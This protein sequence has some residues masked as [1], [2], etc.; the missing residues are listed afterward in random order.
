[1]PQPTGGVHPGKSGIRSAAPEETAAYILDLCR[2][3]AEMAKS[4]KFELLTYLLNM[5]ALEAAEIQVRFGT[6]AIP[7]PGGRPS[8]QGGAS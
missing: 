5:A 7:R 6:S 1:M 3:M 2:S 4:Q 8:A